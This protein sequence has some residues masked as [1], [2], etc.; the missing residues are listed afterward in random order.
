MALWGLGRE[1]LAFRAELERRLP[2]ASISAII[3]D[4]TP[5]SEARHALAEADVL[6]RSPGVSV[7]KPLLR[8]TDTPVTTATALWMAERGG[9]Q[10]IGVTGTKG[11]ST[12]A[13]VIAHLLSQVTATELA[14]NIGRPVIEL[15][16][17]PLD[18]W[19]VCELSSY[20][21]ADLTVG[22][23]VAVLT[24]IS[25]EHTDW[26]G[27]EEQYRAD[28]LRLFDLPGVRAAVRPLGDRGGWPAVVAADQIPLRGAHN[29]QN[30]AAAVAAIRAAGLTVPPLPEALNGLDPLP[31]RLQTVH[32]DQRGVE[33]I[34]DSI[35]TTPASA[36]AALEAFA[37][38]P[39]VLIAGGSDRQQA[40]AELA[41]VLAL[42]APW[43]ALI[44]LPDTGHRL[45]EAAAAQ[46]F[47]QDR[48]SAA[49]DM[50]EATRLA[51]E[52]VPAGG[53]VLLS[54]AAPSF[55]RYANFEERGDEF[56]AL[57]LRS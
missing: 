29:A 33:W 44:L 45:G 9:R 54:P 1:T 18:T 19:V 52:L 16:D 10:V 39:V 27:S 34:D 11:K 49:G 26:H 30:V 48:I 21:I 24:N 28:K 47:S 32:T 3:D 2:K 57:A 43:T 37:D 36:I 35:S 46:G 17:A 7:Y 41:T 22:P 51:R 15:L 56:A 31:H 55:N 12:T 8:E 20:Q 25:R 5:E 6:V 42:R 50:A 38:R 13:T 53:V 4:R 40:H 14:G 23:E